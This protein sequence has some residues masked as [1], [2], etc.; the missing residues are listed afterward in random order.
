VTLT[1]LKASTRVREHR[2]QGW[3]SIQTT[4]GHVRVHTPDRKV[5]LTA[6]RLLILERAVPHDVEALDE[7]AFVLAV[8][9]P[10]RAS[11]H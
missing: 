7:S 8:A 6:G 10:D 9:A 11:E 1:S 5:D 3:V 2:T 4:T